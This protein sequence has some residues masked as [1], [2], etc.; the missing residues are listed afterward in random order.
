LALYFGAEMT[1]K[2]LDLISVTGKT[3]EPISLQGWIFETILLP[4]ASLIYAICFVLVW[5]FVMWFLYR[6]N[7]FIKI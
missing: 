1:A 3:G 2:C 7:I 4:I 6:K 5:L